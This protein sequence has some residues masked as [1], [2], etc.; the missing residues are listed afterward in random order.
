MRKTGS[1]RSQSLGQMFK[2]QLPLWAGVRFYVEFMNEA[3]D[4]GLICVRP[5]FN[6]RT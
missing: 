5:I 3:E 1:S 4:F 6:A 2:P